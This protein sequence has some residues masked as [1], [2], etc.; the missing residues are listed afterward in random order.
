MVAVGVVVVAPLGASEVTIFK[1]GLVALLG[2]GAIGL[3]MLVNWAGELSLAHAACVGL[4]A[5]AVA[6][7]SGDHGISSIHLLPAGIA[8]GALLGALVGLPA[9]RAKGLQVAVVTL[10][11]AGSTRN[12]RHARP[13]DDAYRAPATR[14]VAATQ[15]M[16]K[17]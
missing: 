7:L 9:L 5:F 14:T 1:V 3:H 13:I 6:K 11:A 8:V 4:P 10:A 2:I 15:T 16:R 12:Q 17:T